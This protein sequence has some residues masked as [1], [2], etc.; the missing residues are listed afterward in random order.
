MYFIS[1]ERGLGGVSMLLI[2]DYGLIFENV[3]LLI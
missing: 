2:E 1:M 3:L